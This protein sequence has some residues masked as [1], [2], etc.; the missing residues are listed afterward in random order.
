MKI[1][2]WIRLCFAAALLAIAGANAGFAAD[3]AG[4]YLTEDSKG[5]AFRIVLA[6][7]G[8]AT[9]E[10]QGHAMEGTWTN[11]N[12]AA[13]IKWT[14]GWTTVLSRDGEGYRKTVYRPGLALT[15]KPTHTIKAEKTE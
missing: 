7:G 2:G 8:E 14:T 12:G 3:W 13:V 5:N 10:K 11:E 4:K 9:G 1:V 15:D 6:A